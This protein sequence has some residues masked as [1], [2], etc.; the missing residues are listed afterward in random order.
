[1]YFRTFLLRF[2]WNGVA[3]TSYKNWSVLCQLTLSLFVTLAPR[4]LTLLRK[5]LI[6]IMTRKIL[7]VRIAFS[8][9]ALQRS[10]QHAREQQ[11]T[12]RVVQVCAKL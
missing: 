9:V 1:M 7:L 11:H 10:E 8:K 4:L 3:R 5:C 12:H 6:F 2:S